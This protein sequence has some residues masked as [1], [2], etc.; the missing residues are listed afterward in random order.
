MISQELDWWQ[1]DKA[2]L[3]PVALK[4][5]DTGMSETRFLDGLITRLYYNQGTVGNLSTSLAVAPTQIPTPFLRSLEA[6]T[7][8]NGLRAVIETAASMLV[9]DPDFKVQTTGSSWAV[10]RSARKLSQWVTGANRKNKL[11]ET[12]YQVFIDGCT[13]RVGGFKPFV[14]D[15]KLQ[16]ERVR[17]DSIIYADHEGPYS[18]TMGQRHGVPRARL[19]AMYGIEPGDAKDLPRY[20]PDPMY[21]VSWINSWVDVDLVEVFEGWHCSSGDGDPGK[22]VVCAGNGKVLFEEPWDY[23]WPGIILFRWAPSYAG[24]G[25]T[26]LGEQLIPYQLQLQRMDRTITEA[27]SK[28]AIGRVW[29]KKVGAPPPLSDQPASVSYYTGDQPPII[30]P[31]MAMG[32]EYYNRRQ[33]LRAEMFEL[34]GVSIAQ[35]SGAK[36]AGLTAGVALREHNEQAYSRLMFQAQTLDRALE[37]V[38]YAEIAL[39]DKHFSKSGYKVAAPG[40][41][42]LNEID[43]KAIDIKEMGEYEVQARTLRSLPNHPSARAEMLTEWV[44]LGQLDP[45]RVIKLMGARDLESIEDR[46]SI[47]E[48]LAER[49]IAS[50]I[51][52]CEYIAPEPYQ[53]DALGILVEQGQLEYLKG[54][55]AKAPRENLECLRR[56][57]ESARQ[58]SKAGP[59]GEVSGPP[60]GPPGPPGMGPPPMGPPG[61]PPPGAPPMM[62]P[63]PPG[64]PPGPPPPPMQ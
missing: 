54:V 57:I 29:M 3:L 30:Q 31:G 56:L 36:E 41:R 34:A 25:G 18:K 13:N 21:L 58:L 12:I 17:P 60:P 9:R 26:P 19:K 10:Q 61:P 2:E 4:Q 42:L 44:K 14:E 5:L 15:N 38:A 27:I 47:G 50:A 46:L 53:G 40:T 28:L 11:A 43:W 16:V 20:Q 55:F 8:A 48:E 49:Q 64:P 39:A 7:Q 1:P 24:M 59:L 45:K 37:Q 23:D 33:L 22:H 51:D 52:D 32:Q 35:A 62:P 6:L 63:G